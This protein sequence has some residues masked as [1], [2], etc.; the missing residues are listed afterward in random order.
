MK[1]I[2]IPKVPVEELKPINYIKTGGRRTGKTAKFKKI[3]EELKKI[4][5][6]FKII[7]SS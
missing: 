2:K 3:V 7:K 4:G 5:A 6:N 1:K